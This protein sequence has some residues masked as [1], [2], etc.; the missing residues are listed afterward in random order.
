MENNYK[1]KGDETLNKEFC[2]K[3]ATNFSSS[4]NRLG[5]STITWQQVQHFFQ[6]KQ[7]EE[8]E[9]D[10]SALAIELFVDLS[11]A[12]SSKPLEFMQRRKGSL[13]GIRNLHFLGQII[14]EYLVVI[15]ELSF[16]SFSCIDCNFVMQ[17]QLKIKEL[18]FEARSSKDYAW[19][20]VETF[21]NYRVLYN[22][23]LEVRVRFSGFDKA[24]E[25]EWVN[26]ETAV[27]ERSIPLEPSECDLVKIGDLVLCYLDR[28]Y[29][30]LYCDAHVMDV[31]RQTH[32]AK[33][34]TCVFV[35]CY[36]HDYSEE[37]VSLKRLCRRPIT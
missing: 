8:T 14:G 7:L 9:Q 29:Y 30:Q 6:E 1:A 25:D 31:K 34:C 12:N 5:K 21:L 10:S 23:E 3:L 17:V 33:S 19:Y 37:N 18:S 32:D 22:G 27:R 24:E 13:I 26:V 2:K 28:E 36:D 35:V 16:D 20:D 4:S 15:G 11:D